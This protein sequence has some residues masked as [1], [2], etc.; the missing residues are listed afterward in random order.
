MEEVDLEDQMEEVDFGYRVD[1]QVGW[2][3]YSD[4]E[5]QV[6]RQTGEVD[7]ENKVEELD[8]EDQWD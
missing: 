4:L 3:E 7:L 2:V 1:H 8:L 6:D 5:D